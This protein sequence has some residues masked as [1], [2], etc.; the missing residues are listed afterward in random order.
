[1]GQA[2]GLVL[3]R[4]SSN[5]QMPFKMIG[6]PIPVLLSLMVWAFL[7]Y[8]T[9]KYAIGGFGIMLIGIIVYQLS[10]ATKKS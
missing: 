5:G 7:F 10:I 6:Y 9:G 1:M 8:S 3:I 4:K 2:I